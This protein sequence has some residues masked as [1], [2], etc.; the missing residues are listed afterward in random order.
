M[1]MPQMTGDRMALEMMRLRP[2]LP[3]IICTGFNEQLTPE[4]TLE[5]G[6][7]ALLMKPFLKNEA[8]AV[9]R[10]VLDQG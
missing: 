2:H 3:V 4:R 7:R 8:A 5:L 1:T 10:Q 6:I 9:I